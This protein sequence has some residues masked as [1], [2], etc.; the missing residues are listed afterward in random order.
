[1]LRVCGDE[2]R[3]TQALRR[4][5][6]SRALALARADLTVDLSELRFA[7]PSL[8]LDI[9]MLARRLRRAGKCVRIQ[10]A[11]P[12]IMRLIEMVGL[13]RMPG[14]LVATPAR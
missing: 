13:D 9:A 12:Q 6:L 1:V 8:M 2:D 7:D 4:A 5:P 11:R 3:A 14:V 10:G